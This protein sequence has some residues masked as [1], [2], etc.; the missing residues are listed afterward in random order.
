[1]RAVEVLFIILVVAV[2]VE[3]YYVYLVRKR[4]TLKG[5]RRRM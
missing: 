4:M 2:V 1:M 3:I 5:A